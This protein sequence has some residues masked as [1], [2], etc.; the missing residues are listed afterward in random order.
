M[1]GHVHVFLTVVMRNKPSRPFQ[2]C[3]SAHPHYYIPKYTQRSGLT[4][5][6][7]RDTFPL[8][9][10]H[11]NLKPI[12]L[13]RLEQ[14]KRPAEVAEHLFEIKHTPTW[15][16]VLQLCAEHRKPREHSRASDTA[17]ERQ[18]S[19]SQKW[20]DMTRCW[21]PGWSCWMDR[22]RHLMSPTLI[23]TTS[24]TSIWAEHPC[25]TLYS[26]LHP[27]KHAQRERERAR[28]RPQRGITLYKVFTSWL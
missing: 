3:E 14:P 5:F 15:D 18:T 19:L 9:L 20:S 1:F 26:P 27:P 21:I 7:G 4:P 16:L 8:C 13:A 12:F 17:L 25:L 23:Q 2:L 28:E 11:V 10:L 6:Q 22:F 24:V